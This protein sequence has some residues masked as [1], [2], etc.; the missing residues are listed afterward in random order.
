MTHDLVIRGGLIV[1]GTGAPVRA[2]GPGRVLRP[3]AN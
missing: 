3:A 2:G 1:D